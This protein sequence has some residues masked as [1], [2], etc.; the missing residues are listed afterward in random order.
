MSRSY[1]QITQA[2]CPQCEQPVD[3]EIWLIVDLTERPD[4][5]ERVREGRI[6]TVTCPHC[7][8]DAKV[9]APLLIHDPNR[10]R[11]LFSPAQR[12]T[13]EQDQQQAQELTDRLV[14]TLPHPRPDYLTQPLSV[15][16]QFLSA[17]LDADDVQAALRG[18]PGQTL[19][20]MM[21][22]TESAIEEMQRQMEDN[23]LM[24]AVQVMIEARS[25]V[26]VLAAVQAH[27]ILLSD[28]AD[29]KFRQFILTVRQRGQA[30]M[31]RHIEERYQ[32]LRQ[33]RELGVDPAQ[34][35]VADAPVENI[36]PE[37]QAIVGEIGPVSSEAEF[38]EKM[39]QRP[40]LLERLE[41]E[42]Q[43]HPEL[44]QA[45]TG[46]DDDSGLGEI[47][48]DVRPIIRE[49][50]S[51][52][53]RT[54]MPR[55]IQ[56]CQQALLLVERTSYPQLWAR[57]QD[58]LAS[59]L[60]QNPLDDRAENLEG[61]IGAY[62]QALEVRTHEAMPVDWAATMMNLANAYS[63]RICGE[64]AE[65]LETAIDA[66]QQA[67]EV[68]TREAMPVEWAATMMNLGT[69]YC[70]RICG[71]RAENLE[72]A[73]DTYQQALEVTTRE[74]MPVEW[75]E[76]TMNL[77]IAYC[78]RIYGERAENLELAIDA[79]QQALEVR[80]REAMPIEW[81]EVKMNLATAYCDRIIGERAENIEAA[82]DAYQKVQEIMTREAMPIAWAEATSNLATAYCNRILGERVENL[83]AAID[84]Y[85][86]ALEVMTREAMPIEWAKVTMNLAAAYYS[87]IFGKRAE[88]IEAA[89]DAYQQAL[90]VI[91][92]EA[93]PIV[94]AQT[95]VNLAAAYRDRIHGERAGNL[96]A[97]IDAY[98][99][100][101]EVITR[102]AMPVEWAHIV[103]NLA[104]AYYFRI[105][106]TRANNLDA[107]IGAYLQ[108]L[109]VRTRE[110]MPIEWAR[111]IN[112][113][114]NAYSDRI[115]GEPSENIEK[116]IDAY[117]QTL[118]VMTREAMPVEWATAMM[119]LGIAYCNRIHGERAD[120][121]EA[122]IDAYRQALEVRTRKAMPV[123]WAE[124]T[125]NLGVAYRNRICGERGENIET[126]INAYQQALEVMTRE[127]MPDAHRSTQRNLANLCFAEARWAEAG[128]ALQGVLAAN[129]LLYLAAA[130]PEARLAEL[131]EVHDMPARLS[132]ALVQTATDGDGS[133]LQY[134][135]LALEQN[136]ARWLSEALTL[137]GERPESVP[138]E[139]WQ[140]FAACG[141]QVQDLQAEARLTESIAGKREYVVLSRNLAAAH[142]A[143]EEAVDE[144]RRHAPDFMPVPTFADV[145]AAAKVSPL[146]YI[147]ATPAGGL[148]LII[149]DDEIAPVWLDALTD[150][151]LRERVQ[152]YLEAYAPWRSD[153]H[154]DAARTAWYDA[155]E[156]LIAWL[157][158]TVMLPLHA[159]LPEGAARI[160]LIPTGY[161]ALLP[162]PAAGK[163][164]FTYAPNA[165]ALAA[166]QAVAARRAATALLAVENPDGSLDTSREEVAV[167]LDTFPVAGRAHLPHEV[168]TRQAVLDAL[169]DHNVWHFSTHGIAGW[170]QPLEGGLLAADGLITLRDLLQLQA[171][172]RLAVLSACETGVPGMELPDEV[173]GLPTGLL[174]AGVAGVVSSLWTVNNLSTTLL[175]IRFYQAWR[176]EGQAPPDALYAAQ[177]W[178]R[179]STNAEFQAYFKAQLPEFS[180]ERM[181]R[182]VALG[183]YRHFTFS[184]DKNAR[185][186]A[187]PFYW[188]GFYYT[189]V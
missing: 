186:F 136:R 166:A 145:Q 112:D 51:A 23:L 152:T 134:A 158:E 22:Q 165:R 127:A 79:Y 78:N 98:G 135:V 75:A 123:E 71:E 11:V 31:A 24:Q 21:E 117:Q 178:L 13:W 111:T 46:A 65:N 154:D 102:E 160:T 9:D 131:R 38:A 26:D 120:N 137:R 30:G 5:A 20:A 68:I 1:A 141:R 151:A 106:G 113:L 142:A 146:V 140:R 129:N 100:A 29:D 169:P 184:P 55:R 163:G 47:P 107:A 32:T 3:L 156:A 93:M 97:A 61:A 95:M 125:T 87:R 73:I 59:S 138:D 74:A 52:A 58:D 37:L 17:V 7:G 170:R 122:A 4:L 69:A 48:D 175:M 66:Y 105:R 162:L 144:V 174:Q 181:P 139:A 187:H 14:K 33:I 34:L 115:R 118:E 39:S 70:E 148:A 28:E 161:L 168:A 15:S 25:P 60:A 84:T 6:H 183:A 157:R 99:Q 53:H 67:M 50:S 42:L 85:R 177:G 83:E 159:A 109:E 27:P 133:P 2:P 88:N 180:G 147:V 8:N 56:L 130:T 44:R 176:V 41:A 171:E 116:A 114:A 189:G 96:E 182:E 119:N 150:E 63:N 80:T 92:R 45:L 185:P 82:I 172:A 90:E 77:G 12:T 43:K 132:Y 121:L 164:V 36:P 179:E 173:I 89:I 19:R 54:N 149:Y 143:L 40:D 94:W 101:L 110:A 62:Q 86:Q 124:V 103:H 104:T 155:L 153:S 10:Q 64:R 72:T 18:M 49:L 16:R 91:T 167:T 126:A 128:I 35:T 57:L 188:A 76:V 81:A 108:A